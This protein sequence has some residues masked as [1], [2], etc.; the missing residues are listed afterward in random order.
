M[1][2]SAYYLKARLFPTILTVIPLLVFLNTIAATYYNDILKEVSIV[3]PLI[4]GL[5]LSAALLFL[6]V[7]VNRFVAKEVFQRFYFQDEIQM[8]TTN[9]L[10]WKDT[11][12]DSSVKEKIRLKIQQK[13]NIE[14]LTV[15]EEELDELKS[16]KL[17]VTA[18]SQIRNCLRDNKLLL[19]HNIEYGFFRNFLGACLIA[20]LVSIV[21]LLYGLIKKETAQIH[22]GIGFTLI[23]L[24]PIL[25]SNP[26]I[27]RFG[28]Y[29]SKVLYEQFL[30][31]K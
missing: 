12:F 23:Y 21:I 8:P 19:Q 18:V 20:V 22:I 15:G 7:Q 27:K 31:L 5:G 24:I 28:N 13:F 2:I 11:F 14:V 3:L 10:L 9:H 4:S 29:Y 16:R 26:I 30:T 25:F 1:K 17:I 6:M